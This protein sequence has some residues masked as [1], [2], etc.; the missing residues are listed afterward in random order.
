[1]GRAEETI[2]VLTRSAYIIAILNAEE[3][4]ETD[5]SAGEP[6]QPETMAAKNR[7]ARR[8]LLCADADFA[9]GQRRSIGERRLCAP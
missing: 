6:Q 5:R 1:M 8:A 3:T 9:A 4:L 7:T 2:D